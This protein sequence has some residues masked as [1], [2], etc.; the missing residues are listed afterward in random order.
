MSSILPEGDRRQGQLLAGLRADLQDGEVGLGIAANQAG[1]EVAAVAE[2]DLDLVGAFDNMEVRENIAVRADNDSRTEPGGLRLIAPG[3]VAEEV[4]E[5]RVVK[6]GIAA[7]LDLLR[8]KD[9]HHRRQRLFAA[10]RNDAARR[11]GGVTGADSCR[12]TTLGPRRP[13]LPSHSGLSVLTTKRTARPTV[14]VCA[15]ISQSLRMG[16]GASE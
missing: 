4:P 9:M 2:G 3:T 12:A 11:A 7:R 14:T 15:K 13:I 16:T 8:G 1:V 6:Q 5:D 10:S